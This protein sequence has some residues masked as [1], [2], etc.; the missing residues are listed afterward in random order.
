MFIK[1]AIDL[2]HFQHVQ[3]Y[4]VKN[5]QF[6]CIYHIII[7]PTVYFYAILTSGNY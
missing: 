3:F 5:T 7:D 4:Y 6:H 2:F 1:F